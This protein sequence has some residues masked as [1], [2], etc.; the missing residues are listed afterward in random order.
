M[1]WNN[2]THASEKTPLQLQL[3]LGNTAFEEINGNVGANS[4]TNSVGEDKS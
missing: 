3:Q 4:L 2:S 1:N